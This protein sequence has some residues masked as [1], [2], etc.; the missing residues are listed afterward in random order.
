[1]DLTLA[2]ALELAQGF[3]AAEK[4]AQHFKE[5]EVAVHHV[6]K[7]TGGHGRTNHDTADCRMKDVECYNC[8]KQ[9]HIFCVCQT[10]WRQQSQAKA[11]KNPVPRKETKWVEVEDEEPQLEEGWGVG[12]I[13]TEAVGVIQTKA[14]SQPIKVQVKTS[15]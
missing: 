7:P 2:K 1:M 8:G 11:R 10:P 12:V 9:G 4:N 3:E 15:K 5:T 6:A 13:Q 14:H